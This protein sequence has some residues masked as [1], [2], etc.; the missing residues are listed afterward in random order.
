[1][2]DFFLFIKVSHMTYPPFQL[3]GVVGI[4]TPS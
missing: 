2:F 1:M 4:I 3:Y